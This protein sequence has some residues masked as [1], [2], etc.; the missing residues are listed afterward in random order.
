MDIK[1]E[2][3]REHSKTQTL[4]IVKYVGSNKKR[5]ELLLNLFLGDSPLL[6]QRAGW[7]L[8]YCVEA[9]PQLA[10]SFLD[11]LIA[12]LDRRGLHNASKRNTLRLLQ[13]VDIPTKFQR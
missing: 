6:S 7:P 9:N 8:S 3:V 10:I 1:Q 13:Y 5:F 12:N 2:I 11:R 4:R